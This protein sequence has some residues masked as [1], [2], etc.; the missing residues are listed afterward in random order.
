[1]KLL[2]VVDLGLLVAALVLWST[3][4]GHQDDNV[5]NPGLRGSRPPA[6]QHMPDLSSV[7]GI[8]PGAPAPATLRGSAVM[9]VATCMECRSGDVIGGFLGRLTPDDL[10]GDARVVVFVWGGDE[11]AWL[12][13]SRIGVGDVKP[14]ILHVQA[15]AAL[16]RVRSTFGIGSVGGAEESGITFLYDTKGRWRSTY[17]LGQLDRD[18][19]A[20]DLRVLGRR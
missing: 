19:I 11:G 13:Q 17:F 14:T 16:A 18:D 5:V 12:R 1:V 8:E 2:V 20:H 6:G 4:H 9:L 7:D 3:L 10:P 15:P